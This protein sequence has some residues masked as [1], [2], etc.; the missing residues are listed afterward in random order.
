MNPYAGLPF[1]SGVLAVIVGL[2]GD[3]PEDD[4]CPRTM[5]RSGSAIP[6]LTP[7]SLLRD[8]E[9]QIALLKDS[10]GGGDDPF[11]RARSRVDPIARAV[12]LCG[13]TGERDD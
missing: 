8:I 12:D 1:D 2:E 4:L 5:L 3:E 7:L 10:R 13:A 11:L 9:L 6:R